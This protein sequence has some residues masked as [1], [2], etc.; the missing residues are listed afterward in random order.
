MR[1]FKRW[2]AGF[3][4]VAVAAV[5]LQAPAQAEVSAERVVTLAGSL[6]S[7]L[8]CPG[9]WDPACPASSL[10]SAAPYSK[11]FNVPAGTYE[12]KVA[13]NGS[14]DENYGAGGVLNGPNIPLRIEGPAKLAFSYDDKT[15]VVSVKPVQLAGSA[16]TPAD[17][18]LAAPSLRQDLTKERFYFLMADRFAN[19]DKSN[20]AGGLTG[21]RLQTGLDPTDK[22]FYHGGDLAGVI[23]KLDYIK[24]LGTTS[25]W[26]TPSFK[27]RPVQGSGADVSAGYHGYWITDFTQI[28]PHLGTNADMKR[29]IDLAHRK[30][31]KVFFDIITNHTAD[32]IAYQS[33]QYGYIPKSTSPY[34]DAAGNVFDDKAYAGGDT[35]PA[36]DRDTSFPNVPVF[37]TPADET[38]KVPAWLNDPTLYHNRGD[39]TFAGESAEYGDFVG[40]D[41]LFTEQP[42]VR[43]GMIDVYKTWAE[44]GI[45]GFRI[46][47]VKHVNL[48]FW[49]KF[50]PAIL[51]AAKAAGSKQF[52]MFGEVFD[53]DPKFMSTYTTSGAL[54][55]TLDFG[56]QQNAVT[57]AKGGAS[58]ELRDFYANDDYYTDADSNAY[59]LPTFLGNHDMGRV[60]TF[61]KQGG[62]NGP[63]LLARDKLAHSLMYLTRGQPVVYYGDEQGFTGPGGD[64]DA[65]QDMFATKTADYVDDEVIDGTGTTTI[66]S[67]DRFDVNAPM[68][69]HIAGLAKLRSQYPA[70]SDGRQVHRYSSNS[71]GLYAFS[72]LGADNTEYVVVANNST[73]AKSATIPT[74]GPNTWLRPVYGGTKLVRTDREGRVLLSQAPLSVTV[75]QALSKVPTPSKA[76]AV[77]MN[78][79]EVGGR[80]EISAAVPAN[81]PVT[82]TFGYRPV[83]TTDWKR[84]GSDDNAPYRVF[85]D[86]S[87]VPKG[88]LL[89]YRA[90]L[91]DS[92]GHYSV[93]GSYGV[94]GDA[95]KPGGGG[96]T[97]PVVQPANVSVPG[98]HNSEMGCP[99]DW[100]PDC[101]QAQLALDPKDK[102]WKRTYTIPA[103]EHAYKAA[104]NKNWDVNYGA[105][106]NQNGANIS[107]TAP[108]GPITFYYEH[109]RH[110][111]TSSAEGPIITVPGSF[112]SEL[113]CPGD[114]DPSCMRPWLTDADGDGTYTWSTSEI[115]AGAYE[116]K[117]AHNLS[118]DESY[119]ANNVPV[120][121]PA[122]GLVVTFSYAIATHTLTVTT[123]KP[124]AQ[125]D[126]SQAKAYW[127]DRHTLAV[128]AVPNPERSRWR[129]HWSTTGSLKIDA[130]DIGGTSAG[131][132]YD[133]RVVKPGY[134]TLKLDH[135]DVRRIL[136]GQLGLAQYDDAGRLLDATGVQI[137]GVLDD[138]YK[139][140]TNRSYGVTWSGGT[141]TFTLWAPTAQNVTL[142]VGSQRLPMRANEDGSWSLK[143]SR[144]WKNASYRYE[145]TVYAPTTGKVEQNVVTDPYSAA[146]TT[147]ST[148]SVAVDLNDPAGKPALWANTPA[149]KLARS[150]DSTIYELHVRD[151]SISDPT[152]PA[153]H[154]G[155]YLAFADQGNGTKHLKKLA[156]AGLNTVHLLPTFDIASIPETGQQTPACDLK[157][158][159]ADS[160][161]QQAC[162]TAV[163]GKDGFNWGYDPFHWLA[164]EGSYATQKDGL[165]RVAEFRT[166]VGGLHSSGLRVVLDQVFNH[167]PAAGQAP[168]SVMDKVVPGYYQRLN[169][170]GKVETS[171]CC[172]NIATEHAMAEK[173]MID[174]TVS[175]ARNYRVDGF[176]FDL[177][178][179][180]TKSNMLKVRSALDKLTLAKDGV[181]GKRVYL[182]G[183]GW[184]FGEVA[185]DALFVQA[186]QGNLGGT[187]IGTFSDRLRD[188]VRGGG[189]F[190]DNPRVQGFGSGAAS[191]PN[192]DPINGSAADRAK[193][194]AHDTD[195]VQLGL[196][197]NLRSF[198]FRSAETGAT[199]RGDAVDYNGSPAGYADQPDEVVTYVDAHDNETLWDSL[200]Y[201]LPT[202]LP[203][204]D[205]IRMNTL[206]LATTALAQTPS[207]WHAGAD[208]LR[209]KSLDRN[210]YDS[211]DWFNTLDW[212]GAD[213]GF[214]HGLPPKP[215]NEAKW[216][217][218]RPLLGN[219]ALKPTATEVQTASAA[220]ADLLKLRFSTPL[221][222]L[223]SA[224]LI[225]A[226]LSFPLSGT[227]PG[228]V[229]MRI[230]DTVGPDAD[231]KLKGVLVVFNTTGSAVTQTVPGLAG[232]SLSLSPIQANGSDPVVKQTTWDPSAGSVQVPARSVVVLQH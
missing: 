83:G 219:P 14:W 87:G 213:N 179:H 169:A 70:L 184:N 53:A 212:T 52:F 218:I 220:A 199:V 72:R 47:T 222:R 223:G 22:G 231:P 147:D 59:Q 39:S 44:L 135:A 37:K 160:E 183:E 66:G 57:F 109:G 24:S 30:G 89:E 136:T 180:H 8:G 144:S 146:L 173:I 140:A 159:P 60:G 12:Y 116:A 61:L 162:V 74:Y 88:T 131:L 149:P 216:D 2:T 77:Y 185:D 65:R 106:G 128:P 3:V 58:A 105:G 9:D 166:M 79:P 161:Q 75:Y 200:T 7:E 84:L 164:P 209:S 191:D 151:F 119:P 16:V 64:K 143:G 73:T 17:K 104:L 81:T 29:L 197:A 118:W 126:L 214:G 171:T 11:V 153:A 157:A 205:R 55:A 127:L 99:A 28:D 27:N 178:G 110:Y 67:K 54:Q 50:S 120:T 165:A 45:D 190:D 148:H 76:P 215:D 132:S 187:G 192:G 186:R 204:P 113:G 40:L 46:D 15:H 129:L 137:P 86:V 93:S 198:T 217:Y 168:T 95:P 1:G 195:L 232:K 112:Q 85:Q 156:A 90:V 163:A 193:R 221:F 142:L 42:R 69:K 10:G 36:L 21:D 133:A 194:L 71:G 6:Q 117:V 174:G 4:A 155:T 206:S 43:D 18:A 108:N 124:G 188:A 170:T 5:G 96:E 25:L 122:D 48:E 145:V 189:P 35:F 100:S 228:V 107:Y 196:A 125:P 181:D 121:V 224:D 227:T 202:D 152:V 56:F 98:D 207:F 34:Q 20:D 32:V 167:T 203:M 154:R 26:L 226:K 150:V 158:L 19:G 139:S 62:A 229:T 176:R 134:T 97:G 182:Y 211:G 111:A 94:V 31:M 63:E 175:W 101:D 68:Y 172:S 92:A 91:R 49:Q 230:D 130:D 141:P 208:M 102:V 103:G 201:K 225:K 13:V 177:M 41:D 138:V 51:A 80:A 115:G 23:Q 78:A 82:V 33:G 114:W 38:V 210:S 123:S